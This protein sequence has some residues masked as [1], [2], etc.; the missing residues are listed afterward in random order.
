MPKRK[1]KS[2]EPDEVQLAH[3]LVRMSTEEKGPALVPTRSEI[4]RVM[5]ELGRRG[6]KVGG[7]K[8]AKTMTPEERSN[9]AALAARARWKKQAKK[10]N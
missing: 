10:K 9:A 4:S 5:A 1:Q 7:K 6:G 8:R 2:E 3:H